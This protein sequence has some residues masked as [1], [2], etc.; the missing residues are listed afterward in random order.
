M[1]KSA[2][3][4][5]DMLNAYDFD[6]AEK[7]ADSVRE[8]LPNLK[9]LIDRAAEADIPI[10]YVNDNYGDWNSS[11]DELVETARRGRFPELI[12]EIAPRDDVK[13]VIKGRHSIFYATPL[14]YLVKELE[15]DRLILTGQVT[16]QCVLYSALDA[17]VRDFEVAV[18][19]DAVAHIHD[20][21]AEAS[22]RMMEINMSADTTPAA[23]LEL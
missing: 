13:F 8:V 17:Y 10:V 7:L 22:L 21:L 3:V 16:E 5:I 23:D 6:D 14:E 4:V 19:R 2:L 12:E 20:D 11:A 15:V 9:A 18:P 1:S